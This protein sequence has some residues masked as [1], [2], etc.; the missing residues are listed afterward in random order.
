MSTNNYREVLL[1]YELR[2]RAIVCRNLIECVIER[3]EKH[4]DPVAKE[5]ADSAYRVAEEMATSYI[6]ATHNR[7]IDNPPDHHK[8]R[9]NG[10]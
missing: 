6:N 4:D 5:L 9:T 10:F 7:A 3:L 8:D 2:D 1:E